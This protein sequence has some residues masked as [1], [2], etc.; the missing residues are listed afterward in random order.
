[1][2]DDDTKGDSNIIVSDDDDFDLDGLFD[3]TTDM[4]F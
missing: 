1:M 4:K 3:E 2:F